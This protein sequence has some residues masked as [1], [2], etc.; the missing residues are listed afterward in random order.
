M[1]RFIARRLLYAILAIIAA[2]LFVFALSRAQGDPRNLYVQ[3]GGYGVTPE[4]WALLGKQMHLDKPLVVQY[5]YWLGGL[6]HGDLGNTVATRTP[7]SQLLRA[8][9]PNTLKLALPAWIIGILV[10]VPL[11]M[12]S[13]VYRGQWIDYIARGIALLGQAAPQF[14]IAIMAVLLFA[15]TLGWVPVATMGHGFA[16]RNYILPVTVLAIAPL[17]GYLRLTRSAMLAVLDQE[18][19]KLA[20]AKGT[21]SRA[22]VWRH[23]FRNAIIPPLTLSSLVLASLITGAVVIESIFAWPGIGQL[24]VQA[25]G[26]N[27]Y[28]MITG[29]VLF[30]TVVYLVLNFITDLLY[31]LFDPRI[32]YS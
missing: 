8:K 28:P 26:N 32:R 30:F 3:E 21:S 4:T 11:G 10:G 20:R 1:V 14:W 6:L 18:Y 25:V 17:A 23:A 19:I 2:T 13:A 24:S 16:V 7:V 31:G 12:I 15:V 5:G 22:V 29:S 27:D 9:I